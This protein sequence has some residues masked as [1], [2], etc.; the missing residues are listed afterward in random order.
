MG[1]PFFCQRRSASAVLTLAAAG[2]ALLA[3]S[4]RV[5]TAQGVL[6][7]VLY[8][9]ASGT[10]I[11]G[12]VMLVDPATDAAVV[13]NATDS[14][15]RF[16]LQAQT[17]IYRIAAIHPGYKSILSAP[18]SLQSGERLTIR[19]PIA[20][21]GDPSHQIGVVEHVHP[22]GSGAAAP[23]Q[24]DALSGFRAR[25]AVGDGLHYDR[26][27]F[28]RS[29]VTTLGEFL[30]TV[31]GFSVTDPGSTS[32][33]QLMRN[34]ATVASSAGSV[35][36]TSCYLGWFLDGHRIDIPGSNDGMTDGLG[37]LQLDDL[38]GVEIF[39]GLSEM[40]LEF[41]APDLRCGAIAIWTR[42]P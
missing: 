35:T 21:A 26:A 5:A 28:E 1:F 18:I 30:Q 25:K 40:P 13:Y 32:S 11:R 8:D 37:R 29:R 16:N 34:A 27:A 14:L 41:A 39:R 17:G 9:D 31:P 12:T 24:R 22:D 7:G 4:P 19:V 3:V 2:F 15:G 36:P 23:V 10:P 6:R 33:M 42:R 38:D 20:A